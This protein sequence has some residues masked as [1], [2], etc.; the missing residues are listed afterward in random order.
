MTGIGVSLYFIFAKP[1]TLHLPSLQNAYGISRFSLVGA[2]S[3]T[4]RVRFLP[5]YSVSA[6]AVKR[7]RTI[8][9]TWWIGLITELLETPW[10]E[11]YD[12]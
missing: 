10:T 9:I 3:R 6:V 12:L 1:E 8:S 2:V 5:I 7:I 11:I 4:C